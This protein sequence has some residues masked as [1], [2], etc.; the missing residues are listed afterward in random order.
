MSDL[1]D[2]IS[3]HNVPELCIASNVQR[4]CNEGFVLALLSPL[5]GLTLVS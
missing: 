4:G 5:N 3:E 1:V 2:I